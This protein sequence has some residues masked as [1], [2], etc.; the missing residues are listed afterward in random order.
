MH[1]PLIAAQVAMFDQLAEGRF[2]FSVSPGA[3]P[4]DLEE[5]EHLPQFA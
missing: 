5:N 4:S 3:L 1:P 2:I